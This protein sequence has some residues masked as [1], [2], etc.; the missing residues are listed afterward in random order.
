MA[1]VIYTG[2]D[3]C[4][5]INLM[6]CPICTDSF[7][8]ATAVYVDSTTIGDSVM[9]CPK[10]TNRNLTVDEELAIQN[11]LKASIDNSKG[12]ILQKGKLVK[13][14]K[15]LGLVETSILDRIGV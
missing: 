14:S 9:V 8:V 7:E 13:K 3:K 15:M 1:T 12:H 5:V 2:S 4:K 6:E 10:H 11:A